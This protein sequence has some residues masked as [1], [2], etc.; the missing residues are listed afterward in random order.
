MTKWLPLLVLLLS[1]NHAWGSVVLPYTYS[2]SGTIRASEENANN[3][4]LRDEI[5]NHEANRN[6]HS[7]RL[8]DILSIGNACSTTPIDFN[9]TQALKLRVE[10][11]SADPSCAAGSLGRMIWNSTDGLLKVCNGSSYVSIAGTGVNTLASVLSAGNS[12]GA[13][14]LDLNGNQLLTA[15]V[16]N[17]TSDPAASAGRLI[18]RTDTSELKVSNG[19]TWTALGGAQGLSSVLGVSNSAGATNIDFN[20]T[21]AVNARGE[22]LAADPGTLTAGRFYY[23]TVSGKFRFYDGSGWKEIGN[24]N[25]LA[26]TMAIGNSVGATSLNLNNQQLLNARAENLGADPGA[27]QVGRLLFN[28]A[29][30][31]FKY[32]TGAAI[33]EV[34]SLDDAQTF[35]NKTISGGSNTITNIP[36]AALSANVD[37]LNG[38]QTISAKKTFSSAPQISA[39]K[40]AAGTTNGHAIPDGL[41][42]DTFVLAN[43]VQTLAGKTLNAPSLSGNLDFNHFQA[44]EMRAEN[45]AADPAVGHPGRLVYKTTTGE[46]LYENGSSWFALGVNTTPTWDTVL[47]AGNSAGGNNVD[48]NNNEVLNV[49]IENVGALPATGNQ[50]RLVFYN[51]DGRMYVDNGSSWK[52]ASIQ[53]WAETLANG[54]SAGATDPDFNERQALRFRVEN[55]GSD[56]AAAN[57]G[58]LY[59]NTASNSLKLDNGSAI[60]SFLDDTNVATLSNKSMDGGSNT[61]TNLPDSALATSYLKADGSRALSANWNAGAFQITANGV[62]VGSAANTIRSFTSIDNAGNVLTIPSTLT[63][64]LVTRT[65]TE[66]LTNKTINAS[67]NTISNIGDANIAAA[68]LTNAAISGTAAIAYSKLNLSGSIVNADVS[69]SAAIARSKLASGTASHVLINDGT[70]A[71]SSEAQLA[72]SRGGTGQATKTAAFDALSPNTTKGDITA[73]N[74]TNNVRVPVGSDGQVLTADSAQATGVKWSAAGTGSVTSVTFTGDGTVLSSTPSAA[75]TTS[76]TVTAS[77][78][79]QSANTVLAGPSSGAAASPTFR[80]LTSSDQA[81][82]TLS[83]SDLVN[84]GLSASVASNA[85][86]I[87]LKQ[88]DGSTDASAGNPVVI[89]FRSSTAT[90][91][92]YVRRTVTGALSVTVSSGSTLGHVSAATEYVYVYALD[93]SGTVE[94]AVSSEAIDPGSVVTTTA[95]GGAGAADSRTT[96]YSTTARTSVPVRL[97][98]RV[99]V[100]EATAGTW[101][102]APSEVS[103]LPYRQP[104]VVLSGGTGNYR[105]EGAQVGMS[106][107]GNCTTTSSSGNWISGYTAI[108]T[109]RCTVNFTSGYFASV[110]SCNVTPTPG[111]GASVFTVT[112]APTTSGVDVGFRDSTSTA[113]NENFSITCF[114]TH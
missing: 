77:L 89:P 67:S 58:R 98:G 107:T 103:L 100:S 69:G 111:T 109:G 20:G 92:A 102:T 47:A 55:L 14:N 52:I 42:D 18:Y 68:G 75:V 106:G 53:T 81:V 110:F 9:L 33:K 85:L 59:F 76:G 60:I 96:V 4:A 26:Q 84:L 34:C 87:A 27:A 73:H 71:M 39:I 82:Q 1:A 23:N 86:T 90:S 56:P 97:L 2:A 113:T 64:T 49:R 5:N 36:D 95:E 11:V 74:G 30:S 37:L 25:T 101:A 12:A 65:N 50:G 46:L 19:A 35:T 72:I 8:Q 108:G 28:T 99:K 32:D 31:R 29:T 61:F 51:G 6:A 80:A 63:D 17:K 7:T 43:A 21:Q 78:N 57:A 45:V 41:A 104:G 93:N 91:G 83:P 24:T 10:N 88:N 94:L 66:T 79:T 62:Q 48:I 22:N 112:S 105:V 38:A 114:G 40:T 44:V 54:A 13:S 3:G 16:E 70:G 15:R